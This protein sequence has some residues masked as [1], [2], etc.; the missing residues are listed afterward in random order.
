MSNL[1]TSDYYKHQKD[2]S[3][4]SA[5]VVAPLVLQYHR[6]QSII[7]FGCGVGNW[8]S[9]F[10]K[11]GIQKILGL[12][13]DY[14]DQTQLRIPKENFRATD[15]SKPQTDIGQ[16]DMA[17]SLE[18]AEHL[19]HENAAQF[20]YGITQSAP[21]VLFS[22]AVPYQGGTGHINEQWPE[23]WVDLFEKEGYVV[24]DPLR[25]LIW[26]NPDV[27]WW[28]A[29]NIM[30]FVKESRLSEFPKLQEAQKITFPKQLSLL[31]PRSISL[32]T[33]K[34][35]MWPIFKKKVKSVLFK[36]SK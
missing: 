35:A 33:L 25:K 29:Q 8:L 1:Y 4:L 3:L 11:N 18:V 19:P 16:F 13:G 7:D 2:G 24:V 10:Q 12:D 28:Y 36:S 17:M 22:A 30:F 9:A 20:V 15:L 34:F 26:N 5:E 6:P 31:H 14:V 21:V 32:Y 27:E 23:Y